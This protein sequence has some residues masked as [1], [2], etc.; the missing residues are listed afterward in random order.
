MY[1]YERDYQKPDARTRGA[2]GETESGA[3]PERVA[4]VTQPPYRWICAL[5][6]QV[7]SASGSRPALRRATGVLISPR[8]V[9]T[10]AHNVTGTRS[11]TK[12][13]VL[14]EARADALRITVTPGLDGAA[15]RGRQRA[16][17]GSMDLKPGDWWIPSQHYTSATFKW[18]FAV[19]TLPKELPP[20]NKMTYG[21]WSDPRYAPRTSLA[22]VTGASLVG[23]T[24]S[25]AGYVAGNCSKSCE[26]CDETSPAPDSI[27]PS[28]GQLSTQAESSGLVIPGGPALESDGL[29]LFTGQT[30]IGMTGAPVWQK[31]GSLRLV[32]IH[33]SS[34]MIQFRKT[35]PQRLDEQRLHVGLLMRAEIV[36]L[37]RQR[38][39]IDHVR[40]TF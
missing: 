36:A 33:V 8:H 24:V 7:P 35:P 28:P 25:L 20:F 18:D 31:T 13:G 22:P 1:L 39:A 34:N 2:L 9:L 12:N 10:A 30:C 21:H 5:D 3:R 6:I 14:T 11:S 17:V 15:S 23:G 27:P 4:D 40:P 29:I 19:L 38:L 32:A 26:A 16:P 37:L